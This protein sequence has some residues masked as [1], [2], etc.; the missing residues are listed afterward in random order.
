[1][2]TRQREEFGPIGREGSFAGPGGSTIY[3]ARRGSR[4][5]PIRMWCSIAPVKKWRSSRRYVAI[6]A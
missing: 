6:P 2:I 1:M 3:S 5:N 4:R